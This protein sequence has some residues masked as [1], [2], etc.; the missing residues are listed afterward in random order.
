MIAL[1][2]SELIKVRTI[3]TVWALLGATAA[4]TALAVAGAVIVGSNSGVDLESESGVGLALHVS[5]V[6]A[7]FVLVLGAIV[8]AGEFRHGT[9]TSTFLTTP[10]RT[11]VLGA[12]VITAS[13]LGLAFGALS[14]TVAL[15]VARHTYQM[16]GYTLPVDSTQLRQI[17]IGAIVYAALFGALG[18]SLGSLVRNQVVAIVGALAWLLIAE[19]IV[20]NL[21]PD[22]G[23]FLPASVG[24]AL[25]L[26]PEALLSQQ[27]AMA[28][29]AGYAVAVFGL[30]VAAEWR[31]DAQ[32][33]A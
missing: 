2:R 24:R 29:L 4:L 22:I 12:K 30:A 5:G 31:R 8:T 33:S 19:Q 20:A 23:K 16:Q 13:A 15:A 7:V 18:A 28:V 32:T 10:I 27:V 26:D 1:I 25:V 21:A 14:A 3:R 9:A 17:V 11:R 6:G